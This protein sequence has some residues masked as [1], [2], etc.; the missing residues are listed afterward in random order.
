MEDISSSPLSRL[1]VPTR[2]G[3]F[4]LHGTF[5]LISL[6]L[7]GDHKLHDCTFISVVADLE[8]AC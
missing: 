3:S 6:I 8:L 5:T 1:C 7:E 4:T 2:D